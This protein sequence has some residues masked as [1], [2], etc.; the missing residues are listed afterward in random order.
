MNNSNT[1]QKFTRVLREDIRNISF[2]RD[3]KHEFKELKEFYLNESEKK[4]LNEMTHIKKWFFQILWMVRNLFLHLTP[5]RRLLTIAGLVFILLD[6]SIISGSDS[7]NNYG[8]I[9]GIL[10]FIVLMLELKDKLLAKDELEA[11]RKVQ[12]ALTPERSPKVEGWSI[13]LFTRPANEV[14]GDLIDYLKLNGERVGIILADIAGKG[15]QAALLMAK[16]QAT[17]RA[18][19]ADFNSISGLC[20]KIN[21]IFYRDSLPNIFASMVYLEIKPNDPQIRFVNAGHFPPIIL[22]DKEVRETQKSNVA[23]GLVRD[24]IYNEDILTMEKDE[25]LIAYTDGITEARNEYGQFFE[26][27]RLLK[28]LPRLSQYKIEDIGEAIINE[29]DRFVG[30]APVNDDLSLLIIKKD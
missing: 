2:H 13:W 24:V 5:I 27:E 30:D 22:T 11:G 21:T 14:G 16:L 4:Q 19:A 1:E 12:R 28:I 3:V 6:R 8:F 10:V 23:I 26:K 9:G 25:M 29:I 20:T 7:T 17:I 15:L 18:L